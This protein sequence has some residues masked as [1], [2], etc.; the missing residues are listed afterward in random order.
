M[1]LPA[2][3]LQQIPH[4]VEHDKLVERLELQPRDELLEMSR[5]LSEK[6]LWEEYNEFLRDAWDDV[7][8]D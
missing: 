7:E 2:E 5:F 6:L 1:R 8:N 4:I 3:Q